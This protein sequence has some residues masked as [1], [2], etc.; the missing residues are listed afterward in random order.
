M[1]ISELRQQLKD[2]QE[3]Q[4]GKHPDKTPVSEDSV[5]TLSHPKPSESQLEAPR[6]RAG[7]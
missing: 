2:Y 5:P 7:T 4:S 6:D 1:I 3:S